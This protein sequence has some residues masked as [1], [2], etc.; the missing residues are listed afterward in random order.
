MQDVAHNHTGSVGAQG[1]VRI[2]AAAGAGAM[3]AGQ[4]R[5]GISIRSPEDFSGLSFY[6]LTVLHVP[7][8]VSRGLSRGSFTEMC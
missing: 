6:A 5:S 1:T 8:A 4:P 2:L 7:A 3:I